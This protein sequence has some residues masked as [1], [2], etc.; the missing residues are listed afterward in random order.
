MLLFERFNEPNFQEIL[1]SIADELTRL[2][3]LR[4]RGSLSTDEFQQA[5]DRLLGH[6]PQ[7]DSMFQA[8]D[9]LR[10]SSVD[11]WFG[12][13]CGGLARATGTGSWLWRM[14]FALLLIAGGTGLVAYLVLWFFVPLEPTTPLIRSSL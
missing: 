6:S 2:E 3:Q 13:V 10:R 11:R 7:P 4:N 8:V 1:M 9:G 5:K 14:V 12:G